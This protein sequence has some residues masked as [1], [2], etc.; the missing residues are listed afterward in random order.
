VR[1]DEK[2]GNIFDHFAVCYE[3]ENG[4]KTFAYTRQ[5]GNCEN[6][7]EDY[8]LGTKGRAKILANQIEGANGS[9]KYSGE[10]PSMYD[11]EHVE[12]FAGLRK[13]QH[14]NNGE[15]M[16]YSTLMAIMGREACYTG[17]VITLDGALASQQNLSPSAY[18]WGDV[19]IPGVARP[20]E[21]RFV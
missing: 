8:I 5:M 20:G 13:G 11:H 6:D 19:A 14:I 1:T 7:T 16:S 18:E 3:W 17:Q 10:T 15:Y 12:L 9:W 4:V 21:S 2:W